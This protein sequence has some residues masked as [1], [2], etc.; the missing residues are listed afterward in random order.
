MKTSLLKTPA[1]RLQR[2]EY[3]YAAH[4]EDSDKYSIVAPTRSAAYQ[5]RKE[6]GIDFYSPPVKKVIEYRD[7]FDLFEMV[8]GEGG[9][10]SFSNV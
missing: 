10:R 1:R 8:T 5:L 3:W 4:R 6:R 9:G 7:A 2:L